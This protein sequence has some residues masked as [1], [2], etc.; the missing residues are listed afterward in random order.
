MAVLSYA[1]LGK[2]RV[3]AFR[4]GYYQPWVKVFINGVDRTGGLAPNDA[5]TVL[6]GARVTQ[7]LNQEPDTASFRVFGFTPVKGQEVKIYMG[8]QSL[9]QQLF[10]GRILNVSSTAF[11]LNLFYD[12]DCIDYTW[13]LNRR[14]VTKRYINQSATAIFQDLI[15]TF[16]SGFTSVNVASGLP[17]IDEITFTNEDLTDA[18]TRTSERIGGYW[19]LDYA[20]DLHAFV[21]TTD[22]AEPITDASKRGAREIR[23]SLDLSQ[24]V[25]RVVARG[26]GAGALSDAAVGQ[27]SLPVE[28]PAW[29][30]ASGGSVQVGPQNLTYTGVASGSETGSVTGYVQPPATAGTLSAGTIGGGSHLALGTYRVGLSHVTSEGETI[31]SPYQSITLV[32]TEDSINVNSIPVPTDPKVTGKRLYVTLTGGTTLKKYTDLSLAA[33]SATISSAPAGPDAQTSNTAGFSQE[34]TAAGAITLNVEDLSQFLDEGWIEAPGGQIVRYTG[35]TSSTGAGQLTGIPPSGIGS[36]TAPMRTGT[37]RAV[38]HLTGIPSSSAG[39]IQYAISRGD[40]VYVLVT[41]DD[42]AAQTALAALVGGDGVQEY[43]F[44]DGRLGLTELT[45]RADA[46]LV[47]RKDP[48]VTV[49]LES[50]DPTLSAGKIVTLSVSYPPVSGTFQI[51]RVNITE[52]AFDGAA[53]KVFPKRQVELTSKRFSFEDLVRQIRLVGRPN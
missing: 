36:I 46:I 8:E 17:T 48:I 28:D 42:T 12:L 23:H 52:L 13:L 15:A 3:G 50:R 5:R 7:L 49:T 2:G 43:F 40:Q 25:T 41:R 51:Q 10:G 33:T 9:N 4:L 16:S 31:T 24:I 19:Y 1:R 29:Y 45:A 35:R 20:S 39:S 6:A 34:A 22:T 21:T 44:T 38:P 32:G 27:T 26:G 18:L 47:E 53:M 14:K 30:S 11:G 37:V